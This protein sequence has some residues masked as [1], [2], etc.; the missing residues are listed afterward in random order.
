MRVEGKLLKYFD[1]IQYEIVERETGRIID[2]DNSIISISGFKKIKYYE[3]VLV[4]NK[5]QAYVIKITENI[6]QAIML[7]DTDDIE[8]GDEIRKTGNVLE[9]PVCDDF[10]GRVIDGLGNT[11]DGGKKIHSNMY[12][13]IERD[14]KPILDRQEVNTPLETGIKVIDSIIPIGKGQRELIIGDRQTGK[15]SIAIDTIINQKDKNLICIYCSICQQV[16]HLS[17]TIDILRRND[18]LKYTI[19]VAALP[20]DTLGMQVITPFSATTIA[21]YFSDKGMDVLIVYDDLVKHARAYREES[22]LL[23]K[24]PGR[25]AYPSDIFYLHARLLE[26]SLKLPNGGSITALPIVETEGENISSYIPTNIIS[27]TDGQLYLSPTMFSKNLLPAIDIG[28]SISRVG[29]KAQF[30]ALRNI[31]GNIGIQY[32]QF[33]EFENFSK[34][35]SK[36]DGKIQKILNRGKVIRE[37]FKQDRFTNISL[38]QQILTF[39]C[40]NNGIL[41]NVG[42]SNIKEIEKEIEKLIERD[43]SFIKKIVR[44]NNVIQEEQIKKIVD[45][46]KN[47]IEI[48]GFN[49]NEL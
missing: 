31:S 21:E 32:S 15:T 16:K 30:K 17:N 2:I 46:I 28:K 44:S 35:S 36:V 42:V 4:K 24:T 6:I 23:G 3:K 14:A 48:M 45:E 43:F 22:L 33:E 27:I 39:S 10:I 13:P 29:G 38:E 5:Y 19:V 8:N 11:I 9:I 18:A 49:E 7:D 20:T 26:R 25:E 47:V 41:D 40:V 37:I 12:M 1:G 34:F